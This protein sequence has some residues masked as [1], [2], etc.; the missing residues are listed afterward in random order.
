MLLKIPEKQT[1]DALKFLQWLAF[2]FE[3][4]TIEG[5]AQIT[6]I[7]MD[8]KIGDTNQPFNSQRVYYDPT[9]ILSVCGSLVLKSNGG[10]CKYTMMTEY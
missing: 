3:P 10:Y 9:N 5:L 4:L 1:K 8:Y 2:S 6:G 7:N